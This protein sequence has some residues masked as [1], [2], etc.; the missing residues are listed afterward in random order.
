MP[1]TDVYTNNKET[2]KLSVQ[3]VELFWIRGK[4]ALVVSFVQRISEKF[5]II[6]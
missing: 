1:G 2:A 5:A 3:I 6:W 4:A